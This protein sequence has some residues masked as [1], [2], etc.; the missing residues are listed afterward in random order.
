MKKVFYVIVYIIVIMFQPIL[1]SL[2]LIVD[3]K[4]NELIGNFLINKIFE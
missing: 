3:K 1:L 2:E 4:I